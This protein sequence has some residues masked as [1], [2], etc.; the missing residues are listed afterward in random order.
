MGLSSEQKLSKIFKKS[1]GKGETLLSR[2]FFEEPLS[3]QDNIIPEQI[4]T[5]ASFIPQSAPDLINEEQQ[6]VVKYYELLELEHITGSNNLSYFSLELKDTIPFNYGDGSYNYKLFKNDGITRIYFGEGDWVLDTAGGLLTFYGELPNGI[7]SSNPPKISFYKY[8]GNKGL[9]TSSQ[10]NILSYRQRSSSTTTSE[11]GITVTNITLDNKPS[12]S[13][14][15]QV[16]V[17]GNY[18]ELGENITSEC[19]FGTETTAISFSD[20]NIG[21]TLVWN[22]DATT[23]GL[24]TLDVVDIL[25]NSE[26]I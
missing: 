9:N 11:T 13:F 8:I 6:G 5:N 23:F 17:N 18:Q 22:A 12:A 15:I 26:V 7:D 16:F 14:K 4:W 19:W 1:F 24:D 20:L 10:G 21:D 25:Y 3:S 2:K